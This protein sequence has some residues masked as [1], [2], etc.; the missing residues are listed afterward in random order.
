MDSI[1]VF[2][3]G[4]SAVAGFGL[5]VLLATAWRGRQEGGLLL[6]AVVVSTL[7]SVLSALQANSGYVSSVFLVAAELLRDAAWL[8]FLL[9]VLAKGRSEG[10]FHPFL[11]TVAVI[12]ALLVISVVLLLG[13]A[14]GGIVAIP[15]FIGFDFRIFAFLLLSLTGLVLVEQLFRNT[16]LSQRWAVKYLCLGLGAMFAY[17][18]YLYSDAFLLK[19]LD[20]NI[21]RGRGYIDALIVPLIAISAARNP[22]WSLNV[23]VSRSFVFHSSALLGAGLYLLA[24][25]AGGYYISLYGGDW[26]AA[27]RIV[28][29]FAA[30]LLLLV[31][32]FSGQVR[33]RLRIFLSKHFF[34]YRYDYRDEWLKLIATLS[35]S[36]LD[37]E[38]RPRVVSAIAQIVESPRGMLWERQASGHFQPSAGWN[39]SEDVDYSP[40]DN[41]SLIQFMQR[42]GWVINIDDVSMEP[43]SYPDLQLPKWLEDIHDAWLIVP[44]FNMNVLEGFVLLSQP[45]AHLQVNWEVRDLLMTTGRQAASYLALLK[46]NESLVD[47]RQ[48]EAFNR[49]SAF[50]VHDLK[51]IVAQL[52]LVVRNSARHKDNPDFVEDAFATVENSVNKMNRLLLQLRKGKVDGV[53]GRGVDLNALLGRVVETHA[54]SLPRPQFNALDETL[55]VVADEDRLAAIIGHL[56]QNAQDATDDDGDVSIVLRREDDTALI[57]IADTGCGMD[58]QFIRERLFRPFDTTKGNAG[59]G[60][61]VYESREFIVENG[62]SIDVQSEPGVGT[63]FRIRLKLERQQDAAQES[64]AVT[65]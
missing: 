42:M 61:G 58:A 43:E 20:M 6:F 36:A 12:V 31:L 1:G 8:A 27:A 26:G 51:N 5:S 57:D 50:V 52:S 11:R 45:R 32:L 62:G 39:M 30:G 25:A 37:A 53:S 40:A 54:G 24:M 28:F 35:E 2:G 65:A 9:V 10:I 46:A 3:Y 22:Q 34:A 23:F 55:M 59:M 29:F 38:L 60:I 18:F 49:L 63:T 16:A 41:L 7:W 48:F 17:D 15:S 33:A 47:A 14:Y 13:L 44:L 56:V 4:L 19:V 21:W 64:T